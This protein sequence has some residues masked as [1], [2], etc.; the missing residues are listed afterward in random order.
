MASQICGQG[1]EVATLGYG[2][3][4]FSGLGIAEQ[5]E[6]LRRG[7]DLLEAAT[8]RRAAG[9]RIPD[10]EWKPELPAEARKLGFAWSSSLPCDDRAFA[11]GGSGLLEIPWRY[12]LEDLQ[13]F[14][15]NLEPSFP[16]GQSRIATHRTVFENWSCEWRAAQHFGTHF[17]LRLN[18]E[19]I[20]TPARCERLGRFLDELAG[21]GHAEFLTCSELAERVRAQGVEREEHP[22]ALFERLR[23]DPEARHGTM[24]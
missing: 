5:L 19:V 7:A 4:D 3:E 20:G 2:H 22:Y 9:F 10:G 23:K 24:P 8:G 15:F 6:S 16:P 1:H 17:L 13:Y 12:E 18:A 21:S 14:A 11:L